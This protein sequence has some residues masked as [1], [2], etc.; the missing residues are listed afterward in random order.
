VLRLG[1]LQPLSQTRLGRIAINKHSS[2][3]RKFVN[4]ER[5]KFHKFGPVMVQNKSKQKLLNQ[6]SRFHL[7][8]F[9]LIGKNNF[10]LH[11][12]TN[13]FRTF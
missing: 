6:I 9:T 10:I 7:V 12:I 8:L 2:L 4:Y 11:I 5:K 3:L 1:R 13:I